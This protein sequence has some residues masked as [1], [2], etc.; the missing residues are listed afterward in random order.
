MSKL[1]EW[2]SISKVH[3]DTEI[4]LYTLLTPLY[5]WS[6]DLFVLKVGVKQ[7]PIVLY[8]IKVLHLFLTDVVFESIQ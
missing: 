4:S 3:L 2:N 1:F 5:K 7:Q 6:T 8:A